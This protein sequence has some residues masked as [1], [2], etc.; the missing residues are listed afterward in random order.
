MIVI[1]SADLQFKALVGA[2]LRERGYDVEGVVKEDKEK[3]VMQQLKEYRE[4]KTLLQ[5]LGGNEKPSGTSSLA[6]HQICILF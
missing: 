5:D 4:L 6:H 2:E 3:S 1:V